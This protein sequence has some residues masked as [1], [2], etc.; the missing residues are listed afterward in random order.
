MPQLQGI[1]R[2]LF[3]F[4]FD[5]L[6]LQSSGTIKSTS[7]TEPMDATELQD[8][9]NTVLALLIRTLQTSKQDIE[10]LSTGRAVPEGCVPMGGESLL[11]Y[12]NNPQHLEQLLGLSLSRSGGGIGSIEACSTEILGYS[13][14]T[15]SPMFL[16]KLW[17]TPSVPGI[18][19]DL[20]MSV[21]NSN[22]HVFRTSPAL[23]IIEKH[24]AKELAHLFGLGGLYSGGINV[25]GGAA[26]NHTALLIARNIRF[27]YCRA[28]GL[29][30]LGRRVAVFAS[31]AAHFSI[32]TA[33]QN[34]GLGT[35]SLN[36][37]AASPN[38]CMDISALRTALDNAVRAGDIPLAVC[39][40]AG[41]TVRG[42]FDP[43][44]DIAQLCKD[45]N[46]WFHVD[47]CWG[48][49]AI[50]S[51][52]LRYKLEGIDQADS[53]AYNPHKLLGIPQICSFLL[54]RDMRT[55]W[56]SNNIDAGYLFHQDTASKCQSNGCGAGADT[57]NIEQFELD[58]GWRNTKAIRAAPDPN[59]VYDLASFTAQCG[60]RSDAVKLYFHWQYYGTEGLG[61]QI[62]IAFDTA[63]YL[64]WGINNQPC[65]R[66][67]GDVEVP[68][69]Q[70]CFYYV[71]QGY[72]RMASHSD[73]KRQNSQFTRMLSSGLL[74]RGWMVDYAPGSDKEGEIGDF[75]RVV[76]NRNTTVMVADGLLRALLQTVK[77][78]MHR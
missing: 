44:Q 48:G 76:C 1:G 30:Q 5:S 18:A 43:L 62:D 68:G 39:A 61:R 13:I 17:A 32:K 73:E 25:P 36:E 37:I 40:T 8:G 64:A 19:A 21:I 52:K 72:E 63:L 55:F 47:A 49:A 26:A 11:A 69:P 10:A 22:V 35:V 14:N 2:P 16:D 58:F 23:S 33:V 70:V 75:L 59:K 57:M 6:D 77:E 20:L 60:R 29:P 66:L 50:F 3:G 38:G 28:S 51:E 41:T 15:S 31:E 7:S 34:L 9:I 56:S 12:L 4:Q 27:P 53:I 24:V 71:G 67:L 65:F 46:T 54:G 74:K 42:A 45:Y 78:D